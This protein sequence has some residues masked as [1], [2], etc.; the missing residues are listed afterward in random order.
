M[1]E[2]T[3]KIYIPGKLFGDVKYYLY[4]VEWQKLA[5]PHIHI[6]LWFFEMINP[7]DIDKIINAELPDK[8]SDPFLFELVMKH[9][10]HGPCGVYNPKSP[11][12]TNNICAKKYPKTFTNHTQIG[13]DGYPFYKRRDKS[14][15]GHFG[16]IKMRQKGPHTDFEINNQ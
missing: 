5:L 10:I 3:I 9:M 7:N 11:C 4:A 13:N 16:V 6:L 2:I 12:M 1:K 8:E 14:N 15:G